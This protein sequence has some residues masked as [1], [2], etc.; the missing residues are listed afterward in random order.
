MNAMLP[1]GANM[2]PCLLY[3]TYFSEINND[4]VVLMQ[5]SENITQL[6]FGNPSVRLPIYLQ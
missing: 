6:I 2:F 1:T 5:L 3:L 4:A